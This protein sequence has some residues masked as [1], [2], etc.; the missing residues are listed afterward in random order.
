M[1]SVVNVHV[2]ACTQCPS[3]AQ[4]PVCHSPQQHTTRSIV[5][6][7][8]S[9]RCTR[10]CGT[11]AHNSGVLVQLSHSDHSTHA[12]HTESEDWPRQLCCLYRVRAPCTTRARAHTRPTIM[13]ARAGTI[14]NIWRCCQALRAYLEAGDH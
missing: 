9:A 12:A 1:C 14:I 4:S 10:V 5:A 2:C 6:R 3:A 8:T 7:G 13:C 11:R